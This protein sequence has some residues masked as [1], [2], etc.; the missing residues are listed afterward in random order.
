MALALATPTVIDKWYDGKRLHVIGTIAIGASPLTYAPGGPVSSFSGLVQ[1]SL[2]P[3][4]VRV[5]GMAGFIYKFIKGTT[6]A[7]GTLM[8]F[9][10]GTVAANAPLTEHTTAPIVAGVSG[11]TVD[12]YA[13]FKLR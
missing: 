4:W 9:T 1:S 11:D 6:I 7:S 12:F 5:G 10:E 2:P 8:I 13:I 3:I